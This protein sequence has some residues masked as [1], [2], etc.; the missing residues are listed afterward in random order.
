MA[1]LEQYAYFSLKEV[2]AILDAA[3]ENSQFGWITSDSDVCAF[4]HRVLLPHA[5]SLKKKAHKEVLAEVLEAKAKWD[6]KE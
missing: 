4:L 6:E 2:E 3:I 1:S 5:A